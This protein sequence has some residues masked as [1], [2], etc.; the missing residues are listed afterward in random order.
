[1]SIQYIALLI[2][3]F[4]ELCIQGDFE[5]KTPIKI[6]WTLIWS[7]HEFN[8]PIELTFAQ[9]GSYVVVVSTSVPTEMGYFFQPSYPFQWIIWAP[10]IPKEAF[11]REAPLINKLSGGIQMGHDFDSISI[12]VAFCI[13]NVFQDRYLKNWEELIK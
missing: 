13:G 4:T 8:G 7:V 9:R 5:F 11:I 10:S 6:T 2:I 12:K 3:E 1:M